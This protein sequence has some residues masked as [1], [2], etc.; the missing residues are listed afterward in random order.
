MGLEGTRLISFSVALR[1][2][3]DGWHVVADSDPVTTVFEVLAKAIPARTCAAVDDVPEVGKSVGR[4]ASRFV[5][6]IVC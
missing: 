6:A 3:C 2:I 1:G 5:A 4:V